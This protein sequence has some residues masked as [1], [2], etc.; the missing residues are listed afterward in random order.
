[1]RCDLVAELLPAAVDDPDA[2]EPDQA[3]HLGRCLRCQADLAQ[4][5]RL[6][7]TLRS[8]ASE[9]APVPDDLVTE[10]LVGL[11]EARDRR[12]RQRVAGRR[13]AYLGGLAAATAAGVGGVLVLA[14]RRR[15]A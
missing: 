7:R 10:L 11:D 8:F 13:A 14:T 1:V 4:H 5:R 3:E 12:A 15:P 2:L 6:R 9:R